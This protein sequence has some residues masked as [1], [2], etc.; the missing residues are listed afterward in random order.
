MRQRWHPF[1]PLHADRLNLLLQVIAR[2]L[3]YE[4]DMVKHVAADENTDSVSTA[5]LVIYGSFLDEHSF[6]DILLKA[7][8]HGKPIVAPDLLSIKKY[9]STLCKV[10]QLI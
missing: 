3:G 1:C 4:R 5:D 7:M 10:I 8:C 9:V 6:P 2:K